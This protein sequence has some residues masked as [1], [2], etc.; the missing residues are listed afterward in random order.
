M[1]V[2]TN[3]A[4]FYRVSGEPVSAL[5]ALI[6]LRVLPEVPRAQIVNASSC[7]SATDE[8]ALIVNLKKSGASNTANVCAV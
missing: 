3:A 5:F 8:T 4:V 7:T 1:T 6:F 2:H